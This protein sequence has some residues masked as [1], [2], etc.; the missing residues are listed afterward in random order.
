MSKENIPGRHNPPQGPGHAVRVASWREWDSIARR[1]HAHRMRQ[2]VEGIFR[3]EVMGGLA[4]LL[5][6]ILLLLDF[7]PLS[8]AVFA[9]LSIIDVAIWIFFILEYACRLIVAENRVA[10]IVSPWNLLDLII[11]AVP[12]IALVL[13]AGYGISRYLRVLR[14][15]QAFQVLYI[16]AKGAK[17]RIARK[18]Q[19]DLE[20]RP[21]P[22]MQIRSLE[23]HG[24]PGTGGVPEWN[25]RAPGSITPDFNTHNQWV[26]FS[27]Y[28]KSDYPVLSE[29]THIPP[30]ILGERLRERAYPRSYNAGKFMTV[31]LKIPRVNREEGGADV[32]DITWDG[33]LIAFSA[34][35]V[36]TFSTSGHE[37]V[38]HALADGLDDGIALDGP[39][40]LYL[41]VNHS[42]DIIEDLI[43]SAEEQLVCLETRQMGRLPRNFLSMMYTSQK[44]LSRVTSGL[45]HTKTALE[46]VSRSGGEG[47]G[48]DE[49]RAGRL[50]SLTDRVSLLYDN[51]GHV[52]DSFSWMVDYY[53]NVT[54]FSMNRVMK[55]LAVLTAMTMIP[56][57]IGGLL[58]MNLIDNPWPATLLQM[59]TTVGLLMII[60]AWVYYNLGWLRE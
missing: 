43:L 33:L 28:S 32:W 55:I 23:I 38:D 8:P 29:I 60:T 39:G 22:V 6:P 59:I 1:D 19:E 2:L 48:L 20:T 30:Y 50:R 37:V 31:F 40:V 34:D 57:L 53:L 11:I 3:Q 10:Y 26:D 41:C 24:A 49:I 18:S 17:D 16:G 13:G 5:I 44:E 15:M 21:E 52:S 27:G 12:A 25:T 47:S 45:L 7:V 58:G 46:E 36:M 14:V 9:F 4:L 42:L 51:A 54:S 35:Q 56:T